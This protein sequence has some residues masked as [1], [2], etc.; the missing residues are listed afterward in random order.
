[1]IRVQIADFL[2]QT[3]S[4]PILDVRSPGEYQTGHLPKAISFPLFSD[5]ERTE[6]GTLYKQEGKKVAVLKGLKIV[7]PKMPGFIERAEDLNSSIVGLYCWRGGMRSESMAWLLD[8]YGIDTVVL[9]GGYKA[10]R[11]QLFEFFDQKLPLRV[12]TG[13]TGSKKTALLNC[14][15]EKGEQIIDLEGHA[16][17]QGSSFGNKKCKNQPTTEHFQNLVYENFRV[18]DLNKPIWI[19]DESMRIGQ[20]SLMENLY[21]L[22]NESQHIFLEID[23]A[24]RV[25]FLLED[26]GCLSKDELIDATNSIRKKLGSERTSLAI[27]NIKT[28][29]LRIAVEIILTYYD[30][31][32]DKSI[33]RKKHLIE[34]HYHVDINNLDALAN[35]LVS[36]DE[37]H[38]LQAN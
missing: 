14:L 33:S 3:T 25:D 9:E 31:Q 7:G 35:E 29:D 5:E 23:K 28:G 20:V 1:M 27:E 19:E 16:Q 37:L 12:I 22:K 38:E 21:E 6:I 36:T 32:Y 4:L 17:H 10:Y 24:Q 8:Q 30:R 26:Y 11:K 15:K 34:N 2:S 18:F 13:Y